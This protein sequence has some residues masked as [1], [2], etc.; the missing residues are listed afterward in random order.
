[1]MFRLRDLSQGEKNLKTQDLWLC[2][3]L[4][5]YKHTQSRVRITKLE[6]NKGQIMKLTSITFIIII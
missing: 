2:M 4:K 6:S 1:M 5:V 3:N